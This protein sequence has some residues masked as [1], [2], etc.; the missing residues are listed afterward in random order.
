[1]KRLLEYKHVIWDWNGTLLDDVE[2]CVDVINRMLSSRSMDTL[3]VERY[4]TLIDFPV[5]GYYE[6]LGFDFS[7]DSFE[8]LSEIYAKAYNAEC[9]TCMLQKDAI[10][11]IE[12]FAGAGI[13]QSILSAYR[14]EYLEHFVEHFGIRQYFVKLI[15]LENNLANG[16]TENGLRWIKSLGIRPEEIL[17]IGD[18]V[19]DYEVAEAAGTDCILVTC[20]HHTVE[21][22][23]SCGVKV[24]GSFKE[25]LE[26]IKQDAPIA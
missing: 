14:Q 25:I 3:S 13:S 15:G 22:L 20:G 6:K 4:K 7:V 17:L 8:N 21:K 12:T 2:L 16:K 11:L 1:M 5:K 19:H 10:K 26:S 18:T 24:Y 9:G 23:E